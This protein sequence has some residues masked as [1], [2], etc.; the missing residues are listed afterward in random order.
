MRRLLTVSSLLFFISFSWAQTPVGIWSDHLVYNTSLGLAAGSKEIFSSNGSS[1]LVYNR[2]YS[3]LK[4]LSRVNGLSETGI[5]KIAW[6]EEYETL[7]IAYS[8]TNI[9]LIKANTIYNI[10]DIRRKYIPGRKEVN[11]I[12]AEGRYMY[13]ACSFGIV[14]IDLVRKEIHDTWKP[15]YENESNEV[16]DITFGNDRIYAATS[17]GVYH[18]LMS[19][20]GLAYYGNWL[21]ENSLPSPGGK[22]TSI[23]FSGNKLYTNH[24]GPDF[25]GDSIYVIY[26]GSLLFS[27]SLGLF[28]SSFES[29]VNGFTISS[30][31]TVRF[32][33]NNG[34]LQRT[35]TS[36]GWGSPAAVQAIEDNG[37]I[38]IA[39]IISGLIKGD[40]MTDF[41]ALT[42]PG[43]SS[44]K[45]V[46]I[47]SLNG[48]TLIC[49]GGID[50]SWNN[51]WLPLSVSVNENSE[52]T[53][54]DAGAVFDPLRALIDPADN[55]HVFI[56]TWGSGLLEFENNILK[57][58]FTESNSPLQTIIPGK[59]YVRVC[60]LAMDKS[61]NLWITQTEVPGSV[62]ILKPDGN[63]IINPVTIEAPTIGDIIITNQGHKWIVLPR[64]HGLFVLDDNDTPEYQ[65]DD[66]SRKFLITD[67]ENKIFSYI[68]SIAEDLNGNIWIGSDQ[69]PLVYYNPEKIFDNELKAFRIRIPRNDGSG[70]ADFMLG[71]E[72][73]T[74]IAVD[75]ANR[76]WVGTLSSGA[77]LL[78]PDGA[79]KLKNYNE[80]NTPLFSNTINSLSVDNKT[81]VI[82]FATSKGVI[83]VRGEAT[84]GKDHF[85]DVYSFPNPVREDYAGN[86]TITGLM[87]DTQ[88]RISD[89]SGNLVYK[90]QSD[91]GQA[92]WDLTTYNGK[93]VATGVYLV[94]CAS[95]DG[96]QSCITKILVIN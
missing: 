3:E 64:G 57:N 69:G 65:G 76:K 61:R 8:S 32:Y 22:Y 29:S 96:S 10:P 15:G 45:A 71:T 11:R 37:N 58:R 6:S 49:G 16:W 95:M 55:N 40:N 24:T 52:W 93:R 28:N 18:A 84:E 30:G 56:S 67:S 59:P 74:S 34:M 53:H 79:T 72:T 70:L 62:K 38:W 88:V 87:R 94:F 90:T 92:T 91:G 33:D 5:S 36:Y 19:D 20:P 26:S 4:K 31:S 25:P 73:I 14:V 83:S 82:W 35:I 77:Y 66:R 78:S 86:V 13:L 47:T 75:G 89:V 39:D 21:R 85:S 12:R 44:D 81:G 68:Y 54:L 7:V 41:Y 43:P 60:G 46:S 50:A 80:S 2:E 63:W 23:L 42:L 27:H 1:I 17:N 9:D 48:K 51:L